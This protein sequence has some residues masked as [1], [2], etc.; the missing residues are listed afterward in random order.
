MT[1]GE[2]IRKLRLEA[3]ISQERLAEQLGVSR[4]AVS[5][6]EK[7]LSFPSTENL[8][9]LAEIFQVSVDELTASPMGS[10]EKPQ[11]TPP[12]KITKKW[13]ILAAL[14]AAVVVGLLLG[15]MGRSSE[16]KRQISEAPKDSLVGL[17]REGEVTAAEGSH[18][19][20]VTMV[21]SLLHE[22]FQEPLS[23]AEVQVDRIWEMSA[24]LHFPDEEQSETVTFHCGLEH[25][26]VVEFYGQ[27]RFPEAVCVE[28]P[29]LYKLVRSA[30]DPEID[31][32]KLPYIDDPAAYGRYQTAVNELLRLDF[33]QDGIHTRSEMTHFLA[34]QT[35]KHPLGMEVYYVGF[36]TL[37]EP[38]E[39]AGA[40]L[41]GDAYVDS[42][43][44]IFDLEPRQCL[45]AVD[46]QPIGFVSEQW[47]RENRERF[48]SREELIESVREQGLPVISAVPKE[49][50]ASPKPTAETEKVPTSSN[51]SFAPQPIAEAGVNGMGRQ[52]YEGKQQCIQTLGE[53]A[54]GSFYSCDQFFE[55]TNCVVSLGNNMKSDGAEGWV[56][57]QEAYILFHD[58][59]VSQDIHGVENSTDRGF[60][61]HLPLPVDED[62]MCVAPQSVTEL[63][64]GFL[65][66]TVDIGNQRYCY[67]VNPFEKT[68]SMQAA[69]IDG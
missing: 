11:D 42:Q 39:R 48:D 28:S 54:L 68:V 41:T 60:L 17:L 52:N 20:S 29:E 12:A 46:R 43:L 61:G 13:I 58:I 47:L 59:F 8:L 1:I 31:D 64:N 67:S 6:W 15:N 32:D 50:P 63:E 40:L 26:A 18:L 5:K 14:A 66:Y 44:R 36:Y 38:E 23:V 2:K 3:G 30:R 57:C 27:E 62:G 33:G 19:P 25:P 37:A 9:T 45:V 21:Q 51:Q 22:V 56:P 16:E 49:P 4:Q 65:A 10:A 34:V 24:Q 69:S 35:G 55:F 53:G 7:E